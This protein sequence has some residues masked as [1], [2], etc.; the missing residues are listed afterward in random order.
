[1][2]LASIR[3][4]EGGG[5]EG[6]VGRDRRG[7]GVV[8]AAYRPAAEAGVAILLQF[9]DVGLVGAHQQ[10][11]DLVHVVAVFGRGVEQPLAQLFAIQPGEVVGQRRRQPLLA[12]RPLLEHQFAHR[13]QA[14]AEVGDADLQAGNPVVLGAALLDAFAAF[15]AVIH[16]RGTEN[17]VGVLLQHAV[18]HAFDLD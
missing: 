1:M 12:D 18:H 15:D 17:I 7:A 2:R 3:G 13:R 8:A 16:Q 10:P 11:I 5:A 9:V 4:G 14:V 6:H